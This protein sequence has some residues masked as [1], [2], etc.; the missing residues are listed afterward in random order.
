MPVPC[1]AD[2]RITEMRF[3]R[4]PVLFLQAQIEADV[5]TVTPAI[6]TG[7]PGAA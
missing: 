3:R 2:L 7:N 1:R 6:D 4:L 5:D